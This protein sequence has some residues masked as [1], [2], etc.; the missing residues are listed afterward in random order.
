MR[1][2]KDFV[3][4]ASLDEARAELKRLGSEGVPLAGASSL[5]FL[6][7]KEPK[8]AVDLSRAGLAGIC[9]DGDT[10][11]IGAMTTITA[12]REYQAE[13]WVLG[14]VAEHFVTQQIRNHST[15]GGNIV[16]VFA[17]ADFPVALLALDATMIIRGDEERRVVATEFFNGQPGRL[18][19]A[20]DLLV[21]VQIPARSAGQGFGY[22]KQTRVS[23][24]FSQGTAAAWLEVAGGKIKAARV[25]LGA[26]VT[27]PCRLAAVEQA[28]VGQKGGEKL[29]REAATQLGERNWRTVAGFAPDYIKHIGEVVV[30]DALIRA[31]QEAT[32]A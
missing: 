2:F 17:W 6:K 7:H 1:M 5:L 14:R 4:P 11:K 20:G 18:L 29:F 16:R 25:A 28:V 3:V 23:A 19:K 13:G 32:K 9:A 12:L 22:H 15:L 26:A 8:V 10:F 30:A 31:W 21:G 27:F 24:D